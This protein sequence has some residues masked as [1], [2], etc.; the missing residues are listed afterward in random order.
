MDNCSLPND[1]LSGNLSNISWNCSSELNASLPYAAGDIAP[2]SGLVYHVASRAFFA[3]M[4]I[5]MVLGNGLVISS[6]RKMGKQRQALHYWIANVALAD[7]MVG[8]LLIIDFTTYLALLDGEWLC[9]G[10]MTVLTVTVGCSG[11]SSLVM[12]AISFINIKQATTLNLGK[13]TRSI[14]TITEITGV[15]AFFFIVFGIG[16]TYVDGTAVYI[17]GTC[18][19]TNGLFSKP[20]VLFV[21]IIMNVLTTGIIFF[22]IQIYII[23]KKH[24]KDMVS[25]GVIPKAKD[26]IQDKVTLKTLSALVDTSAPKPKMSSTTEGVLSHKGN[27]DHGTASSTTGAIA[28]VKSEQVKKRGQGNVQTASMYENRKAQVVNLAKLV[29]LVV[30]IFVICWLP[31]SLGYLFFVLC[32]DQESCSKYDYYI[33]TTSCVLMFNSL[34]N[35]ILYAIK[36]PEFRTSFKRTFIC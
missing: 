25:K 22:Q 26:R 32:I 27:L 23:V 15:W 19:L 10:Q 33:W 18:A 30:G 8:I 6:V 14:V 20:F 5:M 13:K 4:G 12:S 29:T 21:I 31:C 2:S 11:T 9:R 3:V 16:L 17:I 28:E 34:M 36:S 35:P 1:T 7:G 24:F